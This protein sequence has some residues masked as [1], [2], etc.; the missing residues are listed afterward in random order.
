MKTVADLVREGKII[1]SGGKL[2]HFYNPATKKI[3][4]V[5]PVRG[6]K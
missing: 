3:E 1:P 5:Q 4:K 2:T 6:E